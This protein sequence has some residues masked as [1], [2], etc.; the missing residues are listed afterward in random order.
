M[1]NQFILRAFGIFILIYLTLGFV[2]DLGTNENYHW[3]VVAKYL[4]SQRIFEGLG[5]TLLLTILSMLIAFVL[6][7]CLALMRKSNSK[8]LNSVSYFY[9][10]FFRGTPIYT[11]L[12]F[13]GLICVLF[14]TF[15][16]GIPF[17][18]IHFFEIHTAFIFTA[19]VCAVLG[20]AIN[21]S[22]YL[23]EII[24]AG[25]DS[26]NRGQTEAGLSLGLSQ[27]ATLIKIVLPQAMRVIIPS[28]GNETISMLKTTSLVIA[29]PFTEDLN[30]IQDMI[31][32]RIFM[33]VPLLLVAAF[34]YLLITSVLMFG[35]YF[36]E[37]KYGK[38]VLSV[39]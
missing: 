36:L 4:F 20:L 11:Q 38:G 21:E 14:P 28:T 18:S 32:N 19:F 6:A 9:I 30:Y 13:W 33:P 23:S 7:I 37:K 3:D 15:A 26:V 17:T 27:F 35:Q 25:I 2:G 1:K 22:A 5:W 39:G 12:I 31:A 29:V 16:L 10:W 34:W 8:I 24:R